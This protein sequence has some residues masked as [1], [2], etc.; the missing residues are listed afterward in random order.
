MKRFLWLPL[1][2]ALSFAACDSGMDE[3]EDPPISPDEFELTI[4]G[5]EIDETLLGESFF[6]AGTAPDTEEEVFIIYF[7]EG[8]DEP[9]ESQEE[10][11]IG[12]VGRSTDRAGEGT[13]SIVNIE[14]FDQDEEIEDVLRNDFV[15]W[16]VEY[17]DTSYSVYG[18]NSGE[19]TITSSS[20]ERVVGTLE[21]DATAYFTTMDEEEEPET[22]Q[23]TISGAF[24]ASSAPFAGM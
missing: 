19:L 13:Y 22:Q 10:W 12:I 3:E 21:V 23:V 17:A 24:N 9:D 7:A 16:M 5:E 14:T 8:I 2:L 15:F 18:S 20:S 11:T 6:Y 1:A 4:S